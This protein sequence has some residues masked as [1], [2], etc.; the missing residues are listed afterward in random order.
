MLIKEDLGFVKGLFSYF[1]NAKKGTGRKA[2]GF[3]IRISHSE[4]LSSELQGGKC[5]YQDPGRRADPGKLFY[6]GL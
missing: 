1:N 6:S 2:Q 4:S 5:D 3:K